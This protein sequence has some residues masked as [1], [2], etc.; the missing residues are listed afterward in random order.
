MQAND[1]VDCDEEAGS[2]GSL[3]G[4]VVVNALLLVFY[5]GELGLR[6][7]TYRVVFFKTFWNN[8]DLVIVL[9]GFVDLVIDI[10]HTSDISHSL[11]GLLRFFRATRICRAFRLLAFIPELYRLIQLLSGALRALFW[12]V[13]LI[14]FMIIFWSVIT[15]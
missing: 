8:L 11:I 4:Y 2:C 13:M 12:G 3:L 7:Y 5:A 9:T 15:M 10:L 1:S 14:I 6:M